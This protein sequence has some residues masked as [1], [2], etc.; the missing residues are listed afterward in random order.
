MVKKRLVAHADLAGYIGDR[1]VIGTHVHPTMV[2]ES[3]DRS[4][5]E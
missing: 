2:S 5:K 4:S 3:A 1:T